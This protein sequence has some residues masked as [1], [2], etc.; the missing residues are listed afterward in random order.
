M[1]D[2]IIENKKSELNT[3]LADMIERG[4]SRKE[5]QTILKDITIL[6]FLSKLNK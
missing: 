4:A 1:S 2:K 5:C 3:I 6:N